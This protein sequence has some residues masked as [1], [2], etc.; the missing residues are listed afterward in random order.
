MPEHVNLVSAG[1]REDA[2]EAAAA[3]GC[4]ET[5]AAAGCD[6]SRSFFSYATRSSIRFFKR[7]FAL[8]GAIAMALDV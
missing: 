2:E 7:S 4:E 5:A 3:A 1:S 6:G 8:L